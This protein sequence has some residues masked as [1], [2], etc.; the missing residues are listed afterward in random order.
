M[1]ARD[2]VFVA[3]VDTVRDSHALKVDPRVD[4]WAWFFRSHIQ[5]H[6]L[7]FV[8]A[9]L[10]HR[11]GT[12]DAD[13]A[14]AVLDEVMREESTLNVATKQSAL[15]Q[16]LR[17]LLDRARQRRA[18]MT[19]G[20][21]SMFSNYTPASSVPP[22]AG[23]YFSPIG[24]GKQNIENISS[25]FVPLDQTCDQHLNLASYSDVNSGDTLADSLANICNYDASDINVQNFGLT[26]MGAD[27]LSGTSILPEPRDESSSSSQE[28]TAE[29]LEKLNSEDWMDLVRDWNMEL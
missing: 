21:G 8:L 12:P 11:V 10:C 7:A 25:S 13:R 29:F 22:N 1:A 26:G 4:K 15:W 9:E 27:M 6:A 18:T 24:K 20:T 19:P 16:P 28:Y 14:W 17:W 2:K 3:S 5:W 23:G